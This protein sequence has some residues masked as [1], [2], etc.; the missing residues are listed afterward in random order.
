MTTFLLEPVRYQ[1]DTGLSILPN[2]ET[3]LLLKVDMYI[4]KYNLAM[5]FQGEQ[6]YQPTGFCTA[7]EVARQQKRDAIKAQL[8]RDNNVNL[9]VLTAEDLSLTTI[10]QKLQGL[11]S[12]RDVRGLEPIAGYLDEAGRRCRNFA[13]R[14]QAQQASA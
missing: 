6:H 2:P 7:E 13:R 5:E 8:L 4:E 12:L 3:N 14:R 10:R 11:A 1:S 9:I